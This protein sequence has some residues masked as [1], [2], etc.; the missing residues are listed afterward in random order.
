[1]FDDCDVPA[2]DDLCHDPS[3][4]AAARELTAENMLDELPALLTD[5]SL[6]EGN[7]IPVRRSV[8]SC[9]VDAWAEIIGMWLGDDDGR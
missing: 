9:W 6:T 5:P 1:M 4:E 2:S 3:Y 8:D 7:L